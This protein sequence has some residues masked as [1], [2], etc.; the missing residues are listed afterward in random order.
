MLTAVHPAL[1]P[2]YSPLE[3]HSASLSLLPE[4]A[5][6][7]GFCT[8]TSSLPLLSSPAGRQY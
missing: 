6:C 7:T 8:S 5:A 2:V 1:G 3:R 4:A